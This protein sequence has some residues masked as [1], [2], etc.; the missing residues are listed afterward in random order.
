MLEKHKEVLVDL[1]GKHLKELELQAYNTYAALQKAPDLDK[2]RIHRDLILLS[3]KVI[4]T[5]RFYNTLT[6]PVT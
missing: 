1:T 2:V 4:A 6:N 5:R 3:D